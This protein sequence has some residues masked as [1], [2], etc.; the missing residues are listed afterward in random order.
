VVVQTN[1]IATATAFDGEVREMIVA[2]KYHNARRMAL[3]LAILL[4]DA[5]DRDREVRRIGIDV[6]T[7]APTSSLHKRRRGYDQAELIA[8]ELARRFNLPAQRLLQRHGSIAQTGRS[9]RE[10]LECPAFMAKSSAHG[11]RILVV[12]DVSTTGAT[13][14]SARRALHAEGAET[15]FCWAVAGTP[16]R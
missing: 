7:W 1:H 4:A 6:V 10:R 14:H 13:L 12:D 2:L 9:R 11:R 8:R 3:P 15:V 16:A 5:L